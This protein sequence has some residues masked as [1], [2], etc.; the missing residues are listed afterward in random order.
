MWTVG[1][2]QEGVRGGSDVAGHVSAGP[3]IREGD[4]C[5]DLPRLSQPRG[6]SSISE[7]ELKS[8]TYVQ[9]YSTGEMRVNYNNCLLLNALFIGR[10]IP[11]VHRT[12]K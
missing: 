10:K 5:G 1:D 4:S 11:K 12:M 7:E 8:I 2:T 3:L 6:R 9:L